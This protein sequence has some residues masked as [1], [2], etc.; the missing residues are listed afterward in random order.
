MKLPIQPL[1]RDEATG[2]L[3]FRS[4][5]IVR[6]LFEKSAFSL[7]QL[8]RLEVPAEDQEQFAQLI[9]LGVSEAQDWLSNETHAAVVQIDQTGISE[10]EARINYLR[11]RLETLTTAFKGPTSLLFEVSPDALK[12]R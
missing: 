11:A 4:N 1:T 9:G 2:E 5:A 6:Y 10:Q 12:T 7:Y 8:L 3:R